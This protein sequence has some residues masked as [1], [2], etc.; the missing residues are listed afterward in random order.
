MWKRHLCLSLNSD[1]GIPEEE[2]IKLFKEVGFDGFFSDWSEKKDITALRRVADVNGMIYQSIHAPFRHIN[3]MWQNDGKAETVIKALCHCID[4]CS[5]NGIPVM[6]CHAFIGFHDHSPSDIGIENFRRVINYADIKG[7]KIAFENTEGE[8]Y[9]AALMNKFSKCENVGFCWDTG[10][11]MCYNHS[12]NM[13]AQYGNKIFCT[14]LNDN[15]G[16][17][18]Y[19][20]NIN[21]TDD[22]HLLPFDGIANWQWIAD[23]LKKYDFTDMLTFELNRTSKPDRLENKPY[24][25]MPIKQ[26]I[27]EAYK[28]ACK[29]AA[30]F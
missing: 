11:E 26:Y 27:T 16:I 14:H 7:V 1:F 22:L 6:V 24:E 2:Q 30:L 3:Q 25:D 8:E 15:L 29:V 9:L 19:L 12:Q 20:G 4:D 21:W 18:N 10:H 28:R 5:E 17:S 13:M 23:Q